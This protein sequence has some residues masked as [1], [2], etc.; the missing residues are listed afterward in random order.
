V[1]RLRRRCRELLRE[2]ISQTLATRADVEDEFRHLIALL[3]S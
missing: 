2:E 3:R 1:H